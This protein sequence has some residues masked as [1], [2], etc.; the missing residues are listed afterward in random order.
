M[1]VRSIADGTVGREVFL[2]T[3]AARTP[4]VRA[5]AG[6]PAAGAAGQ[7]VGVGPAGR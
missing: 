4:A 3:R 1:A 5:V 6:G 7:P 2:L